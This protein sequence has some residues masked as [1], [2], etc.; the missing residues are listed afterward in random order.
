MLA[1]AI[2]VIRELWAGGDTTHRGKHYTVE[3]AR[4]YSLP[5]EPPPIL[6]A[7][8]GPKSASLAADAGDGLVG[9]APDEEFVG[10]Y[11]KAGG[12]GPAYGQV[13]VCHAASFEEGRALAREV[14]PIVGIPGELS[15]ELPLPRHFEQAA[16]NVTEDQIGE[17]VACGN[18]PEK[19]LEQ[20]QKFVSAGF[21]H[22]FVHQIGPGVDGQRAAI[23][24]YRDEIM[25]KLDQLNQAA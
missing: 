1:E 15:Q 8:S 17:T 10:A 23:G 20:I 4:V 14:W 2:E 18:D 7:G 6:V 9:V 3:N 19:H 21:T 13:N 11:R 25:P 24:F 16:E 22:V 12:T 5:E